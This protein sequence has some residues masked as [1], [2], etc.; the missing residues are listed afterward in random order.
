MNG[1]EVLQVVEI[2]QNEKDVAAEDVFQALE[3]A[4]AAAAQRSFNDML[5]IRIQIDRNNGDYETFRRWEVVDD[6]DENFKSPDYQML[7]STAKTYDSSLNPGDYVEEQIDNVPLGRISAHTAKQVI[8]QKLREAERLRVA[9]QYRD[10]IGTL[11]MGVAKR[12]DHNGLYVDLGANIEGFISRD[13]LIPRDNIRPGYRVRAYLQEVREDMRGPQLVMSRTASEFLTEL[14]HLE[15]PEVGQGL[16]EIKG[17]ARDPG[18]RAKIAVHSKDPRLDPIGACVGMRGARV[19]AVSNELAGERVDIVPWDSHF[20]Q[21]VVN[22]MAPANIVSIVMDEEQRSIDIAVEEDKLSQA[23]GRGGQNVRLAS[24]L[25]G[26]RLNV[27]TTQEA[28]D[29]SEHETQDLTKLLC[30]KL[31]VDEEVASILLQEGYSSIEAIAY[32]PAE[33]LIKVEEFDEQIVSTLQSRANDVLLSMALSD[34]KEAPVASHNELTD[35]EGIDPILA[36]KLIEYGIH[37]R[38][39]LAEQAVDDLLVIGIDQEKAAQLIM[40]ARMPWF[41]HSSGD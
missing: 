12:E 34:Q 16:I 6:E 30:Q 11:V 26:W 17:A 23:I 24:Q 36:A 38:E 22:A 3:A 10:K 28:Q 31:D 27:I 39:E 2:V 35:I 9:S 5:D 25:L 18:I 7:L 33:D 21:Y 32:A 20:A 29:K 1:K 40:E 13:A 8:V 37:D 41:Q 4:L 14:F 19:Q 15:V